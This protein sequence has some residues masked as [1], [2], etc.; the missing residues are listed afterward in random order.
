MLAGL[1]ADQLAP[2]GR[3]WCRAPSR[4]GEPVVPAGEPAQ[5]LFLVLAGM[6]DVSV[7]Q[8]EVRHHLSMF[9]VG[10]TF[11][12][13]YAVPERGYDIDAH[14]GALSRRCCCR[15]PPSRA[16]PDRTRT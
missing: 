2:C 12:V 7:E 4:D 8:A 3:G 14:A 9:T 1:P 6:I 15:W 11:G 16:Q 10:T 5:G 13:V